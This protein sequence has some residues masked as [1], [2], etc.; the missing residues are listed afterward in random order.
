MASSD[1]VD[2]LS[3]SRSSIKTTALWSPD[4]YAKLRQVVMADTRQDREDAVMRLLKAYTRAMLDDT[5]QR[6]LK[7]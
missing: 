6:W 3:L 7:V 1:E 4:L 5:Q 2:N